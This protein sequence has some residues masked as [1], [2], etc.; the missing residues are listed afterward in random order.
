MKVWFCLPFILQNNFRCD[1]V[2][3][4]LYSR[5]SNYNIACTNIACRGQREGSKTIK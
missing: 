2:K 1:E 4:V 3:I 5:S